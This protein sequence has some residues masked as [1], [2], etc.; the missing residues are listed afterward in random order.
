MFTDDDGSAGARLDRRRCGS[1]NGP[2]PIA[3]LPSG[4]EICYESFGDPTDP[5]LLLMHGLG[6]QMLVWE[7]GL[8][9][10]LADTGLHVVRYDHR[11]SGL[12]TIF[13]A[14]GPP[15]GTPY[16]LSDMATDAVGVL[17][18]LGLADAHVVGFSLGGMVAQMMAVEH[19]LRCRSLVS[20]GS[21]TGNRE[22]GRPAEET[23]AAMLVP[24][25]D[26]PDEAVAKSLADRRLWASVWHDDDHARAVFAA[27]QARSP[28][29]RHAYD[30]QRGAA[31]SMGDRE[32][33]LATITV[34]TR[35]VSGTADTLVL[36]AAGERTA[37]VIPGATF[38]LL[39]GWGHDMAPGAWP[40]L[41]P[42]ISEHC[43]AVDRASVPAGNPNR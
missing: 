11:D 21:T 35:V 12:S 36:P 39:D 16:D 1:D 10:L 43:H 42:A 22:F 31:V 33:A 5:T 40:I 26:D 2:V 18:H 23:L 14:D 3:A 38:V 34:P 28:Q 20:M 41:V 19:P 8:C 9:R 30:R 24:A 17:D 13:D 15:G 29:P 27:Y 37:A 32:V 7:E 6:S 25:P 4:V